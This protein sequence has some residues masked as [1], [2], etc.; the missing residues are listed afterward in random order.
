[1]TRE[2]FRSKIHRATVTMSELYYEGSITIDKYLLE[3]ANILPYEKV[4]V[5]NVNNG[6]RLETYA[7][8]GPSNSGMICLNGPAARLGA[9]GDEVIIIAYSQ[10]TE[11]EAKNYKPQIVLVD[12]NNEISKIL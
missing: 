1:M 2:M 9:V 3:K 6:N 5:V 4:Q 12:K 11:D 10:M 7:I 8:E